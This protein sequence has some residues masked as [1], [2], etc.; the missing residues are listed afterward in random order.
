MAKTHK[1][2]EIKNKMFR[3]TVK[4]I[5]FPKV[6]L[7]LKKI[8]VTVTFNFFYEFYRKRQL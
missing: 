8:V 4:Y 7:E 2:R 1:A 3:S 6:F 5:N